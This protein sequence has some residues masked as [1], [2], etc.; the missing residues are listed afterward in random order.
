[1]ITERD[2]D[3][4]SAE[5]FLS[6]MQ[7]VGGTTALSAS[8]NGTLTVTSTTLAGRVDLVNAS[9]GTLGTI[10][11]TIN[12]KLVTANSVILICA[13]RNANSAVGNLGYIASEKANVRSAGVSF[14]VTCHKLWTSASASFANGEGFTF[15]YLIL[16]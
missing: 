5:Q 11:V 14:Q 13:A 8:A 10:S 2:R 9:G 3:I 6:P 15:F 7:I 12:S 4:N 1:M 16:N